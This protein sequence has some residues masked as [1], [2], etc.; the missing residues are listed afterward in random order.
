MSASQ[1]PADLGTPSPPDA[2]L[3]AVEP[4]HIPGAIQP[5]GA[6]LAA[7]VDGGLVTHA[8]ANLS[9]VLG[10]A[11]SQVLGR[12]L[13]EIF[14][15]AVWRE[16][17]EIESGDGFALAK[18]LT[19]PG[20]PAGTVH[21]HAFRS[22]LHLC[23]DIEPPRPERGQQ[24]PIE[25]MQAVMTHLSPAT[26]R[27][28]LCE[29]AVRGLKAVWGYDRVMAYRFA[30]DG[31]GEVIAEALAAG[32][33][34]FLGLHYPASDIPP[35]ARLLY[36]RQRVGAIADSSYDPVPLLVAAGFGGAPLDLTHSALR[37]V[38][39]VHREYMRNMNT[40]AS[41]TTAL[42]CGGELWGMLVCHHST[43][44][45]AGPEMR[46][47]A[48]VIGQMVSLLLDTL[49]KARINARRLERSDTLR[50][51]VEHMAAPVPLLDALAAAEH[52]LLKLVDAAGVAVQIG[53][54]TRLLGVTP[55]LASVEAALALLR[56]SAGLELLAVN[57]LGLRFPELA[58]SAPLGSGALL[59]PLSSDS[60]DAILWCRPELLRTINWGG[61]PAE[62]MGTDAASGRL[63]PRTS[64][65]VWSESVSGQSMPW[66]EG[67]LALA[68]ELRTALQA[69]KAQR[70]KADLAR[71]RHYD[72]LTGLAN[73]S[74][75]QEMLAAAEQSNKDVAL[76][77]FDLDRFKAVNDVLG[78]GAGDALL[79]EVG[80]RLQAIVDTD[81]LAAR[82][83]G[84]EF[85]VLCRRA[86]TEKALR[87]GERIRLAI[88]APFEVLGQSCHIA[89]SIG[90]ALASRL[91]GLDLVRA[92]DMA[93]YA[94]KQRGG[95]RAMMF[96]P[97]L[98]DR[99]ARQFELD[100]DLREA[101]KRDDQLLLLYQ[102]LFGIADGTKTL[103][104]FEAMVRWQHPQRGWILPDELI[105][106]AEKAGLVA[107]LGEW[108]ITTALQ[109]G[110]A[111]Q[112][113][114]PNSALWV[115][116]NVS[117]LQL[118][119]ADFC[120][121]LDTLLNTQGFA[122]ADLCLE[123]TEGML[124]DVAISYVLA[125]VRRLGV[126]VAIDEFGIGYSS[127]AR[128]GQLAA[129]VVKLD[130]GFL[131]N[132]GG[133]AR[134]AS[135]VSAVVALAHAAGMAVVVDGIETQAQFD[136]ASAAAAD[137]V[138]GFLFARPMSATAAADMAAGP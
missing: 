84:D 40:A 82:L 74:L 123:V 57:H 47:A 44:R 124:T 136:M 15:A 86:D 50:A 14:G 129:E 83:G 6:F 35:Q 38:S 31:H 90:I 120:Y 137:M 4:I 7:W 36:L 125:D 79:I 53:G 101:I 64:F 16:L 59:L 39:P 106:L 122:P 93:M 22:G 127:I 121:R 100:H 126:R 26:H 45:D 78:H 87:L 91:S 8:S 28:E 68:R 23:V 10:V 55:P 29:L 113:A 67:D 134:G 102:P 92:A 12:S 105:P 46:A 108:V 70:V 42:T 11:P 3:C 37:S 27:V 114:R 41:M 110:R 58:I 104:G 56:P 115:S 65:A 81:D 89:A 133:D 132:F 5:H 51:L 54:T 72:P 19:F 77:F 49:G 62:H 112:Q 116:V 1:A 95:N 13:E 52:E 99:A 17:L 66:S 24:S 20:S 97:E 30:E 32:L 88:K 2:S 135:F 119:Q 94:A 128:L 18:L 85:V 43:P 80:R 76:L 63:S 71:L 111:L 69:E 138:Q 75:F 130:R 117:A 107:P 25:M 96:E 21:L 60:E 118:S 9:S 103:V 131:E 98:Y 33:E 34:P 73:R 48:E 109:Q 61:N